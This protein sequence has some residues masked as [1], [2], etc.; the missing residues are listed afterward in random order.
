V[1]VIEANPNPWLSSSAELAMAAKRAGRSYTQLVGQIVEL[2]CQRY[3]Q[4]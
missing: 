2:A 3:P 1:Y 4:M